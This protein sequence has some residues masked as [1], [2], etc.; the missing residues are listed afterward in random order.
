MEQ[1]IGL[2]FF[3]PGEEASTTILFEK[4]SGQQIILFL[5]TPPVFPSSF[6]SALPYLSTIYWLSFNFFCTILCGDN[7]FCVSAELSPFCSR[8]MPVRELTVV[9]RLCR[10]TCVWTCAPVWTSLASYWPF[11]MSSWGGREPAKYRYSFKIQT[12]GFVIFVVSVSC[13]MEQPITGRPGWWNSFF[14]LQAR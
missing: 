6:F 7:A 9:V 11:C 5:T 2:L 12:Q 14:F 1:I 8:F 4:D 13:I 3:S 10:F